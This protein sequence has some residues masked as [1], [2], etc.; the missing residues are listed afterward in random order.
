MR[1]YS[2]DL[3]THLLQAIDAGRAKGEVARVFGVSVRTIDRYLHQRTLT[4]EV[5][6]KPIPGRPRIIARDQDPR[7]AAQLQAHPDAT[8]E[9]HCDLWEQAQGVPVSLATMSRAIA[10]LGWTWENRSW[11]CG[12][13]GA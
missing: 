13:S 11:A 6:A 4:G 3:R 12:H 5:T 10:R 7:L 9:V 8:L 1:G 2:Q